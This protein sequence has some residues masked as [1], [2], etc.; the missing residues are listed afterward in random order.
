[1]YLQGKSIIGIKRELESR[2]IKSPTGN[3]AWCK[4]SIDVMLSNEKYSGDVIVFKTF[5]SGYPNSKRKDNDGE[6][7]KFLSVANHPA[8]ITKEVFLAVQEEKARRSNVI[9]N[10]NGS[11]R[12]STRYSSS[13]DSTKLT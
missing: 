11:S 2:G 12:K 1:M 8:I 7:N 6:W 3:D 5:N 9:K 4:R 13:R 10:D